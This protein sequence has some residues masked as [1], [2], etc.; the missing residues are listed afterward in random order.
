M[1]RHRFAESSR[2]VI[3]CAIRVHQ[4]MGPGLLEAVYSKCLSYELEK[5]GL[6]FEKEARIPLRYDGVDLGCGHRADFIVEDEL[7]IELKA[8][9]G[10]DPVYEAQLLSYLNLAGIRYGLLINFKVPLLRDGIR[11]VVA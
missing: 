10:H 3:A 8:A 11:S 5:N 6:R 4:K 7:I 9:L 2:R 1:E